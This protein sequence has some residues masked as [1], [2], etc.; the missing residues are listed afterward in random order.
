MAVGNEEGLVNKIVE[1]VGFSPMIWDSLIKTG[2]FIFV[3]EEGCD[4]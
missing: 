4:S 3:E 2:N 1:Q